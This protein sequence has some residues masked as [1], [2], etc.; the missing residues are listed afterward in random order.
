MKKRK[1]GRGKERDRQTYKQT[2]R[3]TEADR[4]RHIG[5][6][7]TIHTGTNTDKAITTEINGRL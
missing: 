7:I 4:Q 6:A 5:V 2:D 3:Q 1:K